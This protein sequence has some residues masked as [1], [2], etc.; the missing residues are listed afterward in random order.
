MVR[1]NNKSTPVWAAAY[2]PGLDVNFVPQPQAVHD[3]F[4]TSA[5]KHEG[6][7]CT[8][9]MGKKLTYGHMHTL[10]KQVAAALQAQGV[11]KGSR[12]GLM[13]PNSPYYIACFYGVLATGA[14]VVNFNPL[15]TTEQVRH[16]VEDSGVTHLFTLNLKK[17]CGKVFPLLEERELPLKKVIVCPLQYILPPVPSLLFRVLKIHEIQFFQNTKKITSFD[18]F[19]KKSGAFKPVALN[20][21]QDLALLQY[22]GGTTGVPKGVMLTH[23]NIT[24]NAQQILAWLGAVHP[25]KAGEI[26]LCILPFFHVFA[27]QVNLNLCIAR[28]CTLVLLPRPEMPK[29]LA[30]I[31]RTRPSLMAGVP[32]LFNALSNVKGMG[33]KHDLSCLRYCI[34][35]GAALPAEVRARF[36]QQT[37]C[38]LSEGYGLSETSP[39]LT[40]N[41]LHE[42]GGKAG[43]IGVPLP[44]TEIEIRNLDNPAKPV[45]LGERG[46]VVARGPQIMAGYWQNEAETQAVLK[47]GWL[48]TGDVGYM[49]ADG[50]VFIT[51]RLKEMINTNGYKVYPRMIEE[52]MYRH[53]AVLEV[54]AVG[55]PH[56]Q[57]GEA[58]KVFVALKN[59]TQATT[60]ELMAYA[61]ENL[62]PFERPVAIEIRD[63]LP[64]TLIGKISKKD[65]LTEQV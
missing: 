34:S 51:D 18:T 60:E 65:L 52:V 42:G 20:P 31:K 13:L 53:P 55:V 46:E 27:M 54:A 2:S 33:T 41:P 36:M 38:V 50:F 47:N 62:N 40:C 25:P 58:P 59:G 1:Q 35:G 48:H 30:A 61:H 29:I 43:S 12:V 56:P 8:D 45:A 49:D 4:F 28:G 64:K 37:G 16:Q 10:V 3:L 7:I 39:V 24:A 14:T 5:A 21:Q 15:Y 6:V 19:I 57:K 9:F 22:T 63:A 26:S 17:L 23:A 44:A 11:G 32:T